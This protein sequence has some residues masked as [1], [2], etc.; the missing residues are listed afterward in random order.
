MNPSKTAVSRRRFLK[1]AGLTGA[2]ALVKP[3]GAPAEASSD[4]VG[5]RPFGRSG[6]QVSMLSLGGM[7][8]IPN[9]QLLLRQALRWGVTYWD[10]ADCYGGG[11][12]E[13]GIGKFFR[14]YP[15]ARKKIFLVTKSDD[16]DPDGMTR[17]L[18]RSLDRMGTSYIDLYFVHGVSSI[19]EI[20][21]DT[22]K[23]AERTKAEGKI[24]LFGFSTH[25][26]MD[27]CLMDASKLGWIDGI[28]MTYNYRLMHRPR[29]KAAVEA[30][31]KAGIGLTAMKT[32]GGGQVRTHTQTEIDMAGRFVQKGFTD[33]Q[34]KLKAVWEN[35]AIASICSDM[36][37]LTILAANVS[38]A[39]DRTRLSNSEIRLF[40]RYA[41]ETRSDYCAGC[42]HICENLLTGPVPVGDIMRYLMY[43]REYGDHHRARELFGRLPA[44]LR[45]QLSK[46]D[47][48][49][50]EQAC[51]RNIA[52]GRLVREACQELV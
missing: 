34:A 7:F 48:R 21:D 28:M 40:R 20:D 24:R 51:P 38:A 42:S 15:E 11:R 31:R 52:I 23:W 10:T 30:C 50:A 13:K 45:E 36:P 9:N 6:I 5:T 2:G 17:L 29:M 26:N 25:S 46:M 14:R 39:L 47:F 43:D 27:E 22:R 41:E 35:P 33:K 1:I 18:N 19:Y 4:T 16:R 32:Q 8:D 44:D 37:N 3:T 49:A 12:S